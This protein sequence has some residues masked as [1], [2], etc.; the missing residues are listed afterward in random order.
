MSLEH[1]SSACR[2]SCFVS[3][4]SS[5]CFGVPNLAVSAIKTGLIFFPRCH[6]LQ[7]GRRGGLRSTDGFPASPRRSK[8][9]SASPLFDPRASKKCQSCQRSDSCAYGDGS[10]ILIWFWP[11]RFFSLFPLLKV[12]VGRNGKPGDDATSE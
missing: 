6:I 8:S 9:T 11:D 5:A 7:L 3:D 12:S 4:F 1:F 2:F 10:L